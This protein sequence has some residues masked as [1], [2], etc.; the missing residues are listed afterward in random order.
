MSA[1]FENTPV[2]VTIDHYPSQSASSPSFTE[3]SEADEETDRTTSDTIV[4]PQFSHTCG[5]LE[6][7]VRIFLVVE[8]SGLTRRPAIISLALAQV[9]AYDSDQYTQ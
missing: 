6:R 1:R 3:E 7:R 5:I 4:L 2:P 8:L 9:F